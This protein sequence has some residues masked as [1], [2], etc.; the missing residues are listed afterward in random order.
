MW[1][2]FG[3]AKRNKMQIDFP[4]ETI[5]L[6]TKLLVPTNL[7]LYFTAQLTATESGTKDGI[8]TNILTYG[9]TSTDM[10]IAF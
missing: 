7:V 5:P 6:Y 4:L 9:H 10:I 8:T 1:A 3:G 2:L